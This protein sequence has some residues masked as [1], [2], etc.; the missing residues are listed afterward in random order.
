MTN[1]EL[2]ARIAACAEMVQGVCDD[3]AV[4]EPTIEQAVAMGSLSA[5]AAVLAMLSGILTQESEP[6]L[7]PESGA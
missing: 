4:M 2:D 7:E 5:C 6:K 3:L 1:E